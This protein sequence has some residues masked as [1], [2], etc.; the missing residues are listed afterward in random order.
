MAIPFDPDAYIAKYI[1]PKPS[2]LAFKDPQVASEFEQVS[3]ALKEIAAASSVPLTITSGKRSIAQNS[4]VGGVPHSYH[5]TGNAIDIRKDVPYEQIAANFEPKGYEIINESDHYHVEPKKGAPV[6][7][8]PFDPDAYIKKYG[9]TEMKPPELPPIAPPSAELV[10]QGIARKY[11]ADPFAEPLPQIAQDK[12]P[13]LG[14]LAKT[15]GRGF[16]SFSKAATGGLSEPLSNIIASPIAT[17]LIKSDPNLNTP[18]LFTSAVEGEWKG[19]PDNDKLLGETYKKIKKNSRESLQ[20]GEQESPVASTLGTVGG[21]VAPGA[22]FGELYKGAK[23]LTAIPNIT[24]EAVPYLAKIIQAGATG[25]LANLGQQGIETVSDRLSDGN[26]EFT[27]V[28]DFLTGAAFDAGGTAVGEGINKVSKGIKKSKILP[29]QVQAFI[30]DIPGIGK[31]F[32]KGRQEKAEQ[33]LEDLQK[34]SGSDAVTAGESLREG[35]K[36]SNTT[37]GKEYEALTSGTMG[38]YAQAPA[39]PNKFQNSIQKAYKDL[40]VLNPDGTINVNRL[41]SIQSPELKSVAKQLQEFAKRSEGNISIEDLD[42]LLRDIDAFAYS[43]DTGTFGQKIYKDLRKSAK[44][45]LLESFEKVASPDEVAGLKKAKELYATKKPTLRRLQKY[46]EKDPEQIVKGAPGSLRGSFVKKIVSQ[47]PS[48]QEPIAEVI[49]QDILSRGTSAR[50]LKTAINSYGRENLKNILGPDKF[51]KLLDVENNMSQLEVG[52]AVQKGFNWL[53][54]RQGG[55]FS[56]H[57]KYLA[58]YLSTER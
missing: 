23:G 20:K 47:D 53:G 46:V 29:T 32:K 54:N 5:T 4:S 40:K 12:D 26:R 31:V 6:A 18:N 16:R 50:T 19:R 27:P 30:D 25:G 55:R 48:L 56:Q 17:D 36:K 49:A 35:V 28:K 14:K 24:A 9:L 10:K 42:V 44:D 37:L 3:P 15:I 7:P 33:A 41:E 43:K 8:A 57:L 52:P 1:Q 22:L 13:N 51:K 21:Y 58:P 38:K 34:L 45:S 2:R 11:A 39:V